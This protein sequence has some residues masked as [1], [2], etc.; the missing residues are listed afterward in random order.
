MSRHE[1]QE[2]DLL[3]MDN[4]ETKVDRYGKKEGF[5]EE[6]KTEEDDE[7]KDTEEENHNK[8]PSLSERHEELKETDSSPPGNRHN[9]HAYNAADAE[10]EE[11]KETVGLER[12][13]QPVVQA[14]G[15]QASLTNK[16]EE[17]RQKTDGESTPTVGHGDERKDEVKS[18]K[19]KRD[20][21]R[22]TKSPPDVK[23]PKEMNGESHHGTHGRNTT[24]AAPKKV[25]DKVNSL[26][27]DYTTKIRG[28]S[29]RPEAADK[30]PVR[31]GSFRGS[32]SEPKG[33]I[34][35]IRARIE[36]SAS[37]AQTRPPRRS[38]GPGGTRDAESI[39][40]RE[41]AALEAKRKKKAEEWLNKVVKVSSQQYSFVRPFNHSEL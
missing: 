18:G 27:E 32:E 3:D 23:K 11:T 25:A 19:A 38:V 21:W 26:I 39:D 1:D 15:D 24:P 40:E 37:S 22:R 8:E 4:N 34:S 16:A 9:I 7:R 20:S 29:S 36:R 5:Q 10:L 14:T 33:H 6:K 28:A 12:D 13:T 2:V 31:V 30:T 17:V 35:E 41:V